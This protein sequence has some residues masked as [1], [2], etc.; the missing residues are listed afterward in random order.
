MSTTTLRPRQ[1]GGI[2]ADYIFWL[3][4][5]N[6]IYRILIQIHPKFVPNDALDNKSTMFQVMPWHRMGEKLISGP[7]MTQF[8]DAYIGQRASMGFI[9]GLFTLVA[10]NYTVLLKKEGHYINSIIANKCTKSCH[11][12]IQYYLTEQVSLQVTVQRANDAYMCQ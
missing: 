7:M 2:F 12:N 8:T 4:F 1:N 10:R 3:I 9:A 6:E 11:I 5:F